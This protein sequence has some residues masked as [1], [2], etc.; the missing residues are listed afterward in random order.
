VS[1][2]ERR[3]DGVEGKIDQLIAAFQNASW[4]GDGQ[5]EASQQEEAP[6]AE[7]S[8]SD[9]EVRATDAA[10]RKAQELDVDLHEVE[11]TGANGQITVDDVRRQNA[12]E[13]R[14]ES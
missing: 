10:R 8:Q 1:G 12:Q 3:L 2:L 4:N 11:G 5:A 7:A 14:G 13:E 9:G 6:Q